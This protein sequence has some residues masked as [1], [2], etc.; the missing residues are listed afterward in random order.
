VVSS[1]ADH[2]EAFSKVIMK[3]IILVQ[4]IWATSQMPTE[5]FR[6]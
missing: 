4:A 6:M 3:Q 1:E 5:Y 2:C